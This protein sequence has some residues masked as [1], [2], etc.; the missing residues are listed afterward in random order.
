LVNEVTAEA[1]TL[2]TKNVASHPLTERNGERLFLPGSGIA[3]PVPAV[4]DNSLLYFEAGTGSALVPSKATIDQVGRQ[5]VDPAPGE[6]RHRPER[7]P[8]AEVTASEGIFIPNA[9]LPRRR[10]ARSTWS[11]SVG[12]PS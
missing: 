12:Q 3:E 7:D 2:D 8:N 5:H 1:N 9:A 4:I 6:L 10:P 11:P